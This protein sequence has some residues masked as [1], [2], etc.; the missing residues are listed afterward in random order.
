MIVCRK[1]DVVGA[2]Q[3]DASA[4]G[5]VRYPVNTCCSVF[6]MAGSHCTATVFSCGCI[7]LVD[8]FVDIVLCVFFRALPYL[9]DIFSVVNCVFCAFPFWLTCFTTQF[10]QRD[11]AG[12]GHH[13]RCRYGFRSDHRKHSPDFVGRAPHSVRRVHARAAARVLGTPIFLVISGWAPDS[14]RLGMQAADRSNVTQISGY[15]GETVRVS[16]V[17]ALLDSPKYGDG[18]RCFDRILLL[19]AVLFCSAF[20]TA[21]IDTFLTAAGGWMLTSGSTGR[22]RC[23]II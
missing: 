4:L 15:A 10:R 21:S 17:V 12:R 3:R 8:M 5:S 14:R 11:G 6:F 19:C 22:R 20:N 18:Q 1:R 23:R 2:V 16:L 9:F 7:I 13:R